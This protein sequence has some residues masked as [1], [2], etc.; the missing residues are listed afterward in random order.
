M[1]R[2][3]YFS[4]AKL[5]IPIHITSR[6]TVLAI[7]DG[8]MIPHRFRL[9]SPLRVRLEDYA[10]DAEESLNARETDEVAAVKR[11]AASEAYRL[12]GLPA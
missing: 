10:L 7:Y 8:K 6:K 12:E 11:L 1:A 5:T 4:P 2:A 3:L 9:Q